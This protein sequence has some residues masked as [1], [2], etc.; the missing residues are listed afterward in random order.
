MCVCIHR[1]LQES[2]PPT[3]QISVDDPILVQEDNAVD[4]LPGIVAD[5]ALR[6]GSKVMKQLVQTASCRGAKHSGH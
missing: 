2:A 4:G 3:F 6:E 1:L 5:N